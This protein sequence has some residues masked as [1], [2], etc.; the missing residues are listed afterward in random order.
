MHRFCNESNREK[1]SKKMGK[2]V[3][4]VN[5]IIIK[6]LFAILKP[7]TNLEQ[8]LLRPEV[9]GSL[10]KWKWGNSALGPK[11][12]W[13]IA[14]P[15]FLFLRN[16]IWSFWFQIWRPQ[17]LNFALL[18][19]SCIV[20]FKSFKVKNNLFVDIFAF[21]PARRLHVGACCDLLAPKLLVP[22]S[23]RNSGIPIE[24]FCEAP[25]EHLGDEKK[26]GWNAHSGQKCP[27]KL[28]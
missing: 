17:T 2:W 15:A 6:K 28:K 5:T 24:A 16:L 18:L 27:K 20:C 9:C 22:Y 10:W 26:M 14:L 7:Q 21:L 8:L 25:Q 13:G 3:L 4:H 11:S 23:N 1:E 19:E 12:I